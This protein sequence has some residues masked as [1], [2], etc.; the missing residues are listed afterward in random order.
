MLIIIAECRAIRSMPRS[1]F[2]CD[3]SFSQVSDFL[4][5]AIVP[6]KIKKM[7]ATYIR[8]GALSTVIAVFRLDT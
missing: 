8:E 5:F 4:R 6:F 7:R 3:F 1:K 2:L